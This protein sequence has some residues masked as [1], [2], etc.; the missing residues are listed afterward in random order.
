MRRRPPLPCLLS[1]CIMLS[2]TTPQLAA[3]LEYCLLEEGLANNTLAAYERDLIIFAEWLQ[4]QHSKILLDASTEHIQTWRSVEAQTHKATTTNRRLATL[5]KFYGWALR[6][7]LI[8]HN[9]CQN[10]NSSK[11]AVRV[12][13][14]LSE[15][16]VD[17]LLQAPPADTPLG[18]RDI[19]MLETLYATGLRVSEL[20]NVQLQ[21]L[22]MNDG[23]I[24]VVGGKGG[25]D[26]LV[27][28]GAQ[29]QDSL[30]NYLQHARQL[31]LGQQ[32]SPFLFVTGRGQAMT[33]QA[34]WLLIKKYALQAC[35][36]APLSP[37]VL[38]HAFATHLLNHGADLR[39]VQLLL[40][41]ADIS[42]TQIYTHVARERLKQ[43]H[44]QHH[45]RA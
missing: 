11:Q 40:G 30:Q 4:E 38:R 18:L 42:T 9:P 2:M 1:R 31:I 36:Q 37:H 20:I 29:A 43:L 8:A 14:T 21:H 41:H 16:Q 33:R 3:F 10:L 26:R 45:P 25:K 35:I 12:P 17:T 32:R 6:Q 27:P 7:Q 5:K 13:A 24:R 39:V 19:A 22:S 44:Q 34:F 23:V 28:L 15:A